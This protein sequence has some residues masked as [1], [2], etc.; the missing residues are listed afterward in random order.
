MKKIN[1][2]LIFI[3]MFLLACSDERV[4]PVDNP[5][6]LRPLTAQE[7]KIVQAGNDFALNLTRKIN[8]KEDGNFFISPLSVGYALGMTF[9]GAAGETK[10]GI[11][12]TLDFGNLTD[13]EINLSYL[14]LTGRLT[15]MDKTVAMEIANSIWYKNSLKVKSGFEKIV[16]EF[17]DA[18]ITGLDF[19]DAGS[20]DII[21]GWIEEKTHDKIKDMLDMIPA[22]AVM[23]LVNAV[24]FKADWT[25]RFDKSAT[26]KEPFRLENGSEVMTDMMFSK[27]TKL[28][29]HVFD[30]FGY[31]EIPYGN[32]QFT[33]NV[34]LPGEGY[35]VNDIFAEITPELLETFTDQSDT[36]TVELKFPRFRLEYKNLL[37]SHLADMGMARAFTF[38]A[39]FPGLFE[40]SLSL[41]I[42]RVLHQSFIEVNEEG[43]EAAAATIVEIV[44]TSVGPDPK[45]LR[46]VIDKPFVFFIREKHTGTILFAGK[47][48][49]P[50]A[51]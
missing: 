6:D 20:V 22:D 16:K 33:M 10:D 25:Y 4:A 5:P 36:M 43:S 47:M 27:G 8:E 17:Y 30:K 1:L 28:S 19:G 49:N 11:R 42:S 37:N 44:E 12:Q 39:E 18:A 41:C 51:D 46:L 2:Y 31:I 13:E 26:K 29:Y 40:E 9:N 3:F 50:Q 21:N 45:P 15:G 7:T 23:Y 14:N 48:M 35:G 38:D 34:L 32:R 24:Y